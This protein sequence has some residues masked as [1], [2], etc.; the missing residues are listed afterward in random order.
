MS[1]IKSCGYRV[2][3][4]CILVLF[5]VVIIE[6]LTCLRVVEHPIAPYG[7]RYKDFTSDQADRKGE[8]GR[9]FKPALCFF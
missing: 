9:R 5:I 2:V 1:V 7:A 3:E 6:L 8:E 4:F